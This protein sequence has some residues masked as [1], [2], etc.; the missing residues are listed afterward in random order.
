MLVDNVLKSR[1][2]VGIGSIHIPI[3]D[4]AQVIEDKTK[5]PAYNPTFV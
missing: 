2:I 5:F 1:A 4:Q 3:D